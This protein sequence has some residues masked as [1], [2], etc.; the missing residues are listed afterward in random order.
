MVPL[1]NAAINK[2]AEGARNGAFSTKIFVRWLVACDLTPG[3]LCTVLCFVQASSMELEYAFH[4]VSS[5]ALTT[6]TVI[7]LRSLLDALLS[8]P[9]QLW[10]WQH[11]SDKAVR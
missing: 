6:F 3:A 11:C 1:I 8:L 10:L 2:A 5:K 9:L 4:M 7:C